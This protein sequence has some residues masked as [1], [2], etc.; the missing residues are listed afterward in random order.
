MPIQWPIVIFKLLACG[1]AG[2]L[3][4][5]GIAEFFQD[6]EKAK[7]NRVAVI[8]ALL[9]IAIGG[10][11]VLFQVAK[12]AQIMAVM[13]NV[14]AG[15]PISLE[16]LVFLISLVVGII[17]L[18]LE[19]REE[20]VPKVMGIVGIAVALGMGF[21]SG[22]SHMMM[23]GSPAWHTPAIPVSFLTSGLLLGGFIYLA[24]AGKNVAEDNKLVKL[25]GAIL[26]VVALIALVS[27]I[28]YG[29][30][31]SLGTAAVFY[32]GSVPLV[33]G[34]VSALAALLEMR[35]PSNVWVFVGLATS[36]VGALVLRAMVWYANIGI[37]PLLRG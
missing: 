22:Y 13:R 29:L 33:G 30:Y 4:F 32:W 35:K 21:M 20:A 23:T 19:R 26:I 10:A 15:S 16:F 18:F 9:M 27:E 37:S 17:Y 14:T 34:G 5:V 31:T 8:V 12:P 3:G 7:S 25:I 2:V 24:L 36:L 11:M 28:F 1:G 6:K